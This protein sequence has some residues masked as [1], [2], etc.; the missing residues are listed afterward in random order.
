MRLIGLIYLSF[1]GNVFTKKPNV[2]LIIVDDLKPALKCFGDENAYTPNIDE[3]SKKSFLFNN[4]FAQQALCAPSRN[5]LLTSR[6]PDSLHLYDFYSYWRSTVGNFT[7]LPQYF[8]E[9]GYFSYSIG[10][11][12]HPGK[13][14]NFTDDFPYSW[15]AKTF[16]P[17]TE[18]YMNAKTC[19]GKGGYLAR[20]LICPVLT[21]SQPYGTL[22]DLESLR[23]AIRFLKNKDG[24]TEKPFFLAVGFHKP[25]IP[26]KFPIAYLDF[27][28]INNITLPKNR[29]RPSE[30]PLV[31]WNPWTD[32]RWRDDMKLLDIPFPFG[33]MP[34][35]TVKKII[36][37]YNAAT[38]YI[39]DLIGKL[40]RNVD[41]N[42]IIVL[43]SDHGWS[44]GEHGE[45]SKFSNFKVA[46]RVPLLIHVPGLSNRKIILD[47]LVELVDLFPTLVDLTQVSHP[48][49]RCSKNNSENLVCTEGCSLVPLLFDAVKMKVPLEKTA[50]F[51]QYPRPGIFPTMIPN[52]DKPKL[53]DIT[54]MGYSIKTRLEICLMCGKRKR[55]TTGTINPKRI[56][57]IFLATGIIVLSSHNHVARLKILPNK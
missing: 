6:R 5:S 11:V 39:D 32:I 24:I 10:K 50:I 3:L 27:H 45:F 49:D 37:A 28:P 53:K 29:Y 42:T 1:F 38:S 7:T 47:S 34:D 12:F 17:K 14:S 23:E 13:S 26:F 19:I 46:T 56:V 4:A 57:E 43:T 20:N 51:T 22:P 16:H 18:I 44:W 8:K 48:L 52:S 2:L 40:L 31:A 15:S 30:L 41:R 55:E 36:Q 25:H 54:I 33:P 9:N 35:D 21:E